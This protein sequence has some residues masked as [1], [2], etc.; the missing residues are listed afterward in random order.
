MDPAFTTFTLQELM[1]RCPSGWG[2]A[3][4]ALGYGVDVA[5]PVQRVD[6]V[7]NLDGQKIILFCHEPLKI[8]D[9]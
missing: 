8:K 4:L 3:V 2:D 5:R 6:F 1:G 9:V 7:E